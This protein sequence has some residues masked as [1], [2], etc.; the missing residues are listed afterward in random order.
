MG[1]DGQGSR[2]R[3][4]RHSPR[5]RSHRIGRPGDNEHLGVGV[6]ANVSVGAR[7]GARA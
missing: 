1:L 7:V 3:A 2:A 5:F 4:R 6:R